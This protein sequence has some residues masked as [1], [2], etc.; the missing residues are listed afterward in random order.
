M[1]KP[2]YDAIGGT[3]W[4]NTPTTASWT[5]VC[6]GSY[7]YLRVALLLYNATSPTVTYNSVSVP[8]VS[9]LNVVDSK[10]LYIFELIAP[11]SGTIPCGPPSIGV[12]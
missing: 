12:A 1:A 2:T 11:A 7:L 5:H 6:T 8:L 4:T 10:H 3:S 9:T